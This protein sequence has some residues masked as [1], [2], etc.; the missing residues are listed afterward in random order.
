MRG[1]LTFFAGLAGVLLLAGIAPAAAQGEIDEPQVSPLLFGP[2]QKER[3]EKIR[4]EEEERKEAERIS[5]EQ[6]YDG[7]DL[8][9]PKMR[10]IFGPQQ[11]TDEEEDLIGGRITLGEADNN[12]RFFGA[13]TFLVPETTNLSLGIGPQYRPDYF[14]SDDYAFFPDPQVYVKFKNFVFLDDDGLDFAV[15]GFSGFRFGPSLRVKGRRDESDNPALMGL[16]DVGET[17]EF[18]GFV[19]TTF[20]DRFSFKAKARHGIKTGHRGTIIDGNL[21]AL[22]FKAG[23]ISLSASAQAAWIDDKYADAY[24]SVTPTQSLA[25]G[26]TLAV[27]D[28]NQGIRNVGASLN[29]YINIRDRWSLNPY[30][31]YDYVFDG[32]AQTPIIENFGSRRQFR[33]GFHLMREFTFGSDD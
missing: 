11:D 30:A 19:A 26:G 25:S 12:R 2:T 33:V 13:L 20:L 16:G 29:G 14:G 22:L 5:Q 9:D 31:S 7:Q 6:K 32:I 15:F 18:G 28:A 27:Y 4:Q 1:K 21:T 23:P 17:F 3:R 24:F 10:P 8:D